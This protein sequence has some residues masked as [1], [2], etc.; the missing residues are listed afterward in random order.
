MDS[1]MYNCI[2]SNIPHLAFSILHA[3]SN[4][5]FFVCL[6]LSCNSLL[7]RSLF[8]SLSVSLSPLSLS[9][10]LSISRSIF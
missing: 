4:L 10:S 9:L 2:A 3:E 1:Y 5:S 8:L 7:S 6:F